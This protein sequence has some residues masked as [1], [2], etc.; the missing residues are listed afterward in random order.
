[1]DRASDSG[2]EGWGFESLPV[3]QINK[4]DT[5]MGIPLIYFALRAGRDSKGRHQCA[6]WCIQQ[7]GGLLNSPWE[8]PWIWERNPED[9]EAI[10][11]IS[12][13]KKYRR[14]RLDGAEHLFSSHWEE[15][16]NESRHL[17]HR[18]WFRLSNFLSKG[19]TFFINSSI[20]KASYPPF[21]KC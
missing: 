4:R 19:G 1:M 12:G 10:S 21:V 2:S 6:H 18:K 20:S 16:A 13:A 7:S 3:Y 11:I 5:H 9:C 8:S 17:D 14:R 15:N